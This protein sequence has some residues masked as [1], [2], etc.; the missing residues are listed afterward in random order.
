MHASFVSCTVSHFAFV[1][2]PTGGR[3]CVPGL[4]DV[5]QLPKRETELA[6]STTKYLSASGQKQS[7]AWLR[8]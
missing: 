4:A 8:H 5:A 6:C 7:E 1:F 2:S 3:G